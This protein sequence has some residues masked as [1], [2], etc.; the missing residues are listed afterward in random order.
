MTFKTLGAAERAETLAAVEATRRED[1]TV[2]VSAVAARLGLSRS[3][4]Q[5]RLDTVGIARPGAAPTREEARAALTAA[6]T[7]K[8]TQRAADA[9]GISSARFRVL[10]RAAA[11]YGLDGGIPAGAEPAEGF[12]ISSKSAEYDEAGRIKRQWVTSTTEPGD[13][14]E[15]PDGHIVKGVS[16]LV[17]ADGRVMAQWIKTRSDPTFSALDE[18]IRARFDRYQGHA[19]LPPAPSV[20]DPDK[21]T[22]YNIADHHLGMFAWG[23][24]TGADY[25]LKIAE[26][27]L[28]G[29]MAKLVAL[30]PPAQTA[31]VLNLGDFFHS[32]SNHNRT[33]RS[34]NALDVDSRYAKILGIGVQLMID[35]V[36]L[37]LQKHERVIVR[38]LPG[39]HDPH[40]ALAL[41]VAL[42][43]FFRSNPRVD[44]DTDPSRFFVYS[45]GKTLISATHGDM[46]KPEQMPGFLASRFPREWGQTEH[47]YAYFGH[48]HH[49]S[50]GGGEQFGVVWETFQTLAAKD[51]WHA[52]MGYVSGRSMVAITHDR[53]AGE[54]FRHITPPILIPNRKDKAA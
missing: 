43:A 5:H 24:E 2:N 32:D 1:G 20:T 11:A 22:V 46:L 26:A 41:T 48:V 45:F 14:F 19:V 39:N 34:G 52:A 27:V 35:C 42:A 40:S 36:E 53:E 21:L 16:A 3:T 31:V 29:A 6:A 9:I 7:Y 28:R 54:E 15:L 44:I 10:L 33:E 51:S 12:V 4:V 8:S 49:R 47:R 30:A 13:E 25:D 50:K 38:C 18:A 23:V 17:D 37:A